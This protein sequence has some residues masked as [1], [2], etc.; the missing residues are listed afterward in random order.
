MSEAENL[1]GD[2]HVRRYRETG[3]EVGHEWKQGSKI[4]LLTTTGRKT[5]EQR[6][7]PLIY[8]NAGDK[9]VIVASKGGA[10]E[11]PGWYENLS[12]DPQVELQVKDEIFPA[13]ARTAQ[14]EERETLWK[15]AAQQWPAYDDYQ[16]KT[17]R[18]IPV[19][20]L[21]RSS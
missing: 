6:T 4:L 20:V 5:G 15:L 10:P 12:K 7:S 21:E 8:E 17:D 9:Y 18:E 3:G 1:F 19:V 14:G 11:H 13:R 2:E 16:A